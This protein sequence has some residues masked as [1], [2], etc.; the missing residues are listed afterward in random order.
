MKREPFFVY[1]YKNFKTTILVATETYF[2][3]KKLKFLTNVHKT[4]DD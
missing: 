4:L 2:G 1:K 3:S